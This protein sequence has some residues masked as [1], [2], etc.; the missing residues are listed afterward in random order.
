MQCVPAD[1]GSRCSG[2]PLIRAIKVR[3][4]RSSFSKLIAKASGVGA[5]TTASGERSGR[6]SGAAYADLDSCQTT[7]ETNYS[8][9]GATSVLTDYS[10]G[11]RGLALFVSK[12]IPV[13]QPGAE[14]ALATEDASATTVDAAL[15][16]TTVVVSA[17]AIV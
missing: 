7:W 11:D 5:P 1:S 16:R 13:R 2:C 3:L 14:G 4:P 10:G 6:G 15:T 17:S 12:G 9:A 8:R